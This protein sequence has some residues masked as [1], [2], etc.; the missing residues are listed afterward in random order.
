MICRKFMQNPLFL[1]GFYPND[2]KIHKNPQKGLTVKIV[3]L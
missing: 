1:F 3:S 2:L